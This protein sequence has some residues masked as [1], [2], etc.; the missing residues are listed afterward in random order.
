MCYALWRPE[1]MY[2]FKEPTWIKAV[3]FYFAIAVVLFVLASSL[4]SDT[5][6][7]L[8][9]GNAPKVAEG[10]SALPAAVTGPFTWR[11]VDRQTVPSSERGLAV[12]ALT[13]REVDRQTVPVPANGRDRLVLTIVPTEDQ[14]KAGRKGLLETATFVAVK[15]QKE[16]GAP[17]VSVNMICQEADNDLAR[18]LLAHAVYVADGKG[19]DGVEQTGQWET[20]RAAGRGFTQAELAYLKTYA[21]LYNHFHSATGLK[22]KELDAAVSK[23]LEIAPGSLRPFEN[24]LEAVRE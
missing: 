1:K 17:V 13:W 14:A 10:E 15:A 7:V 18:R 5:P 3:G 24:R 23:R 8:A 20:L 21:E 22:E 2:P 9:P 6:E 11:E 4:S 12:A 19:Y 16:S